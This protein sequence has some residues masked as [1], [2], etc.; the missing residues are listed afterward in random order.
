MP[1]LPVVH[2]EAVEAKTQI[3][4]P[5]IVRIPSAPVFLDHADLLAEPKGVAVDRLWWDDI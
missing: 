2:T 4:V 5:C 1:I 3:L